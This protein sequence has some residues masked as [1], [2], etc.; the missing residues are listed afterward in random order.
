MHAYLRFFLGSLF[1]FASVSSLAAHPHHDHSTPEFARPNEFQSGFL[2]HIFGVDHVLAMVAVGILSGQVG[3]RS[4]WIGPTTFLVGAGIGG[5]AGLA[6]VGIPSVEMLIAFSLIAIG[7]AL[8]L[9]MIP[10]LSVLYL[11]F[12]FFGF[13]HGHVH[14]MEIPNAIQGMTYLI[15]FLIGSTLLHVVGVI[16]GLLFKKSHEVEWANPIRLSG[17]T[18]A[19]VGLFLIVNGQ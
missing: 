1:V 15:G 11:S 13:V 7:L 16:F 2:H 9:K 14:G 17:A 10:E 6:H 19:V 3:G 4:L 5:L 8:T 18:I 12:I